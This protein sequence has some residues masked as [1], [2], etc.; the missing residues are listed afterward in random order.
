MKPIEVIE[1]KVW[2]HIPTGRRASIYG[3]L[4]YTQAG[5]KGNWIIISNG[6]TLR[7]DNGTIGYGQPPFRTKEEAEKKMSTWPH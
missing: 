1:S 6:F 7:M 2:H 5:D 3:A 4:P